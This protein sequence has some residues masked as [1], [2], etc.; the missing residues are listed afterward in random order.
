MRIKNKG[1]I[2]KAEDSLQPL[3]S[4]DI[5]EFSG[6]YIPGTTCLVDDMDPLECFR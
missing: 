1:A 5:C 6:E 3:F 4:G 2:S